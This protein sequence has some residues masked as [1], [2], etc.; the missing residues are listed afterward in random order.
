M[1]TV[2]RILQLV[3]KSNLTAKEFAEKCGIAAGSITDWKTGR[4]KPSVESLQKI[5][6]YSNVSIEWLIGVSY[7]KNSMEHVK[8]MGFCVG[9]IVSLDKDSC[10]SIEKIVNMLI[11]MDSNYDE[12][13]NLIKLHIS[14]FPK[15]E[16]I[17]QKVIPYL[18]YDYKEN[19]E[20]YN[21]IYGNN[22]FS[23]STFLKH[24]TTIY[25]KPLSFEE[26]VNNKINELENITLISE[27][28]N[29]S[30][31]FYMCPVYSKIISKNLDQKDIEGRIPIS[32][33][34]YDIN[35][36]KDYFLFKSSNKKNTNYTLIHKNCNI[37]DNDIVLVIIND[38]IAT[39]RKFIHSEN[40][41]T[42][43][44]DVDIQENRIQV[45]KQGIDKFNILGKAI[46]I[47]GK[48]N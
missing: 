24:Y 13:N 48:F 23:I 1:D 27:H 18:Y 33:A 39:L 10:Y 25:G 5:A 26:K 11:D 41:I 15:I 46:G 36:T 34:I 37:N 22:S 38:S 42:I 45:L 12:F 28:D 21:K 20:L 7:F 19:T 17:I 44:Q 9:C 4:S 8:Q 31:K 30:P 40:D 32:T 16:S 14:E 2:N 43:F 29:Y 47:L 35:N 6:R 3:S